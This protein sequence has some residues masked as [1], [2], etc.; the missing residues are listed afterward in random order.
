[1]KFSTVSVLAAIAATNLH[2]AAAFGVH[3]RLAV[4]H[5]SSSLRMSLDDLE[6]KLLSEP[7]PKGRKAAVK[8][9]APKK[10]VEEPKPAPVAPAKKERAAKVKYVDLPPRPLPSRRPKWNVPR[11]N[12]SP[13]RR[14][15]NPSPQR[16]NL[17]LWQRKI[18]T[19]RRWEWRW[20]RLLLSWLR[21]SLLPGRVER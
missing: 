16:P 14:N 8:K 21:S 15:P 10:P 12:A 2:A 19:R 18:P 6:S 5:R 20:E 4:T 13:A 3:S 7:A 9:S 17:S 11:P 1:M